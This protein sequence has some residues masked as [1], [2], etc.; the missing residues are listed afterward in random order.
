M[1]AHERSGDPDALVWPGRNPG[2][3]GVTYERVLD[4]ASFRRD[5]L[6]PTL[7]RLAMDDGMRFHDLRHTFASLM[8][9]APFPPDEV[10]GGWATPT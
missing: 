6:K 3:H 4:V 10:S 8:L 1:L 5:Y 9:A 2:S 7:R